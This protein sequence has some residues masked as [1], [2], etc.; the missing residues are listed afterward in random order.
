M[1]VQQQMK[2]P[3]Q[4]GRLP[5][6]L[7]IGA[8]VLAFTAVTY[9]ISFDIAEA[10]AALAQNVQPAT[11]PRMVLAVIASLTVV[12]MALGLQHKDRARDFP[13]PVML[14]T[15]ALMVA[16]AIAFEAIGPL[17]AMTLFCVVMPLIWGAGKSA[18]LI[19]YALLFPFA[20]YMLFGVV[21]DVN[22]PPGLIINLLGKLF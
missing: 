5:R 11:F 21:L 9:W 19:A 20:I 3:A 16:F 13:K 17:V 8:V 12:M 7:A 14:M 10:P 22:F 15:G 2:R 1:T 4:A 18:G 6:D